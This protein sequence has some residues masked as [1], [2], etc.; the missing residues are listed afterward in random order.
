MAEK[1]GGQNRGGK[2]KKKKEEEEKKN[3]REQSHKAPPT[4]IANYNEVPILL[5]EKFT[6]SP[7]K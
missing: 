2:K 5:K 1:K 4:E 3:E 7:P 6:G